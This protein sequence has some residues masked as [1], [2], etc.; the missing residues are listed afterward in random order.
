MT[1]LRDAVIVLT[2]GL[3][4]A[5]PRGA[6]IGTSTSGSTRRAH[7]VAMRYWAAR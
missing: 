4:R 5:S 3:D 1:K 6:Q 2:S 7:P